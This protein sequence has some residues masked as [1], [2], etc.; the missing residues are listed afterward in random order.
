MKTGDILRVAEL[1]VEGMRVI[2]KAAKFGGDKADVVLAAVGALARAVGEAEVGT[3]SI[4]DLEAE[5]EKLSSS[6]V[7]DVADRNAAKDAK[8]AAKFGRK[9]D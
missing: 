4:E 2:A 3:L 7:V 5:V 1:A 9:D 8:L 6:I